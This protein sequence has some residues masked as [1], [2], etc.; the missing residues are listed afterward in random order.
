MQ[1]RVS[2]LLDEGVARGIVTPEQRDQLLKLS[3]EHTE[4]PRGLTG[5]IF[6]WAREAPR[7]FNAI[8]IA[9]AVGA[10]S[11]VFALAWF[12]ADRWSVLGPPGV[13]V[14]SLVYT[15]VFAA[16]A[17]IF[18]REKFPTAH[19]V[20]LLLVIITVP[21]ILWAT[22]RVTGI[23]SEE[24]G[25]LCRLNE[26]AFWDCRS[27]SVV[28]AGAMLLAVLVAMRRIRFS[29]L[30]IPGA[31]AIAVML[32]E[33]ALS[34]SGGTDGPILVGWS[35]MFSASVL[36]TLGYEV[37]RRRG[38]ED[39][40]IWLHL[41]AAVCASVA[42]LGLFGSETESRHLL[43][44]TSLAAIAASLLLRRVVWLVVGLSAL[45][46]YLTWLAT[47]VFK[48]T[49]AFPVILGMVGVSVIL[50]TVW[51]QRAYPRLAT[52]VR[53]AHGTG[54]HFPGGS[55]LLLAP[56]LVAVLVMPQS[57]EMER[58]DR[59]MRA[60]DR[61]RAE[62]IRERQRRD[63]MPVRRRPRVLG[64]EI[65][66]VPLPLPDTTADPPLEGDSTPPSLLP[67]LVPPPSGQ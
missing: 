67:P 11:V 41:A 37:D 27:H 47:E 35:F 18:S 1:P 31:T 50:V 60:A 43:L 65:P 34:V 5:E 62:I 38:R 63:S 22:L 7:G 13:L 21:L 36:A 29:P 56:A 32:A 55:A 4:G 17:R 39:Y 59:A 12:L 57:R 26:A 61:E 66:V 52:R 64:D 14:V 15:G 58:W 40:G 20:A 51:V 23:W 54:A 10:L 42:L 49:V 30:M 16:A 46:A 19:G 28:L 33:S 25:A 44:P 2:D 53:D 24:P 3:G 9:Y 48:S 45:F 8:T 6:A